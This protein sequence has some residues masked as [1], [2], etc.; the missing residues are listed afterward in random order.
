MLYLSDL[1]KAWY[2]VIAI[3]VIIGLVV[4]F[5]VTYVLNKRTP[6]PKGCESLIDTEKCHGCSNSACKYY[7]DEEENLE[8]GNDK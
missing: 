3:V 2:I 8:K 7:K 4:L 1:S 6:V 5:F